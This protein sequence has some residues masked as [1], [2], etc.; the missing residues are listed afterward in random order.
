MLIGTSSWLKKYVLFYF[1]IKLLLAKDLLV[2]Y[3]LVD[4]DGKGF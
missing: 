2:L 3:L 4:G 1:S